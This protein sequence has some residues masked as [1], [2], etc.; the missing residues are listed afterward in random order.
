MANLSI[1][2]RHLQPGGSDRLEELLADADA[3]ATPASERRLAW[4]C[5]AADGAGARGWLLTV[6]GRSPA[7]HTLAT[8]L[9]AATADAACADW[10]LRIPLGAGRAADCLATEWMATEPLP[11]AAGR[12]PRE[13]E[14]RAALGT[15]GLDAQLELRPLGAD[16]WAARRRALPVTG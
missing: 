8:S 3:A 5:L 7:L 9:A 10:S 11:G 2:L 13:A 6:A 4:L 15:L 16:S 1:D 14:L 12:A